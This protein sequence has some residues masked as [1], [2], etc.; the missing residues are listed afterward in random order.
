MAPPHPL[1]LCRWV[2]QL[3]IATIVSLVSVYYL[4]YQCKACHA[5]APAP[6]SAS[7]IQAP[8]P[9]KATSARQHSHWVRVLLLVS[10]VAF[11]VVPSLHFIAIVH[12]DYPYAHTR[13]N[14]VHPQRTLHPPTCDSTSARSVSVLCWLGGDGSGLSLWRVLSPLVEMLALYAV[15]FVFYVS[16]WPERAWPRKFDVW[17]SSH[18]FWHALIVLAVRVWHYN[19]LQVFQFRPLAVCVDSTAAALPADSVLS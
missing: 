7:S 19:L 15:G 17:L 12:T 5:H 8:H 1:C 6:T 13:T 18:Q 11:A 10:I 9:R 4:L 16:H 14:P 2:W 3:Y